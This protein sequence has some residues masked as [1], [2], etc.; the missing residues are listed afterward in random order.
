MASRQRTA[1]SPDKLAR[2]VPIDARQRRRQRRKRRRRAFARMV[3]VGGSMALAALLIVVAMIATGRL[4]GPSGNE[5]VLAAPLA[6]AVAWA[7]I[8]YYF[9]RKQQPSP[10]ALAATHDLPQLTTYTEEWLDRQRRK[11]PA[12]AQLKVDSIVLRL[13]ALTPQLQALDPRTP[14]AVEVRRLLAEELP[15]LVQG[16]QK[17][18]RALQRQPLHGGHSPDRQLLEGLSTID[19]EIDRMHTRLATDDLHA[20]ATQQRYLEMKYKGGGK[21]E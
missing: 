13:E 3:K 11:L 19:G 12:D 8:L 5:G 15:E 14:A 17:V 21:I 1:D 20:L 4:F 9:S 18:P 16:Y 2:R 10:K 6:I 7:A